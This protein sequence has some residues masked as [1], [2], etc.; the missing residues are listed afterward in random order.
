MRGGIATAGILMIL[1]YFFL[2]WVQVKEIMQLFGKSGYPSFSD[3]F[4]FGVDC[5]MKMNECTIL[6]PFQFLVIVG[7][8]VFLVG[9]VAPSSRK[10]E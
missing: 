7:G 6:F 2:V 3:V 8:I 4:G 9:V 1:G 5:V 10:K